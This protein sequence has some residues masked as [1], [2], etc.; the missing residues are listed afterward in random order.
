MEVAVDSHLLPAT[1]VTYKDGIKIVEYMNSTQNPMAIINPGRTVMHYKPAP[2]MTT[3]SA[4][5]PNVVD[6]NSKI[7]GY[8]S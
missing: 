7:R 4:R 1:A 8:L 3:F 5:G 6:L 2:F